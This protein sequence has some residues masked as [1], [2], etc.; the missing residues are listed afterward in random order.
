MVDKKEILAIIP[1]RGGSKG[2]PGKN[3]RP[4]NHK[5]LIAYTIEEAIK[6]KQITRVIVSTDSKEIAHVSE[7]YGAEIPFLRPE[8]WATD[9]ASSADVVIHALKYLKEKENYVPDYIMLLQCTTPFKTSED[10]DGAIEKCME[11]Q[12]DAVVSICEAE[13]N[14]YWT[15]KFEGNR[16]TDVIEGGNA[17]TSRQQ[18]PIAYRLNGGIY[19]IK[20]EI[21]L[22]HK[23]FMPPQTTGY[24]MSQSRSVDIDTL[25]DFNRCEYLLSQ[26]MQES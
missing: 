21:F 1:A 13:V 2:L 10:M 24:V 22:K 25:E 14:P 23:D 20:T 26:K 17:I 9:T 16:L 6:S 12:M 7:S 4:L 18:L 5:P 15:V 8:E 3:I 19:G 11:E